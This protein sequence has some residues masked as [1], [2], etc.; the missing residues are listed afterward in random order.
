MIISVEGSRDEVVGDAHQVL[1]GG[2]IVTATL[3]RERARNN[4]DP[5]HDREA[6]ADGAVERRVGVTEGVVG[7]GARWSSSHPTAGL[8]HL[9]G[10]RSP[11]VGSHSHCYATGVCSASGDGR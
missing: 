10:N 8:P 2:L 5:W 11:R 6:T 7:A 3:R 4:V 9:L 1:L